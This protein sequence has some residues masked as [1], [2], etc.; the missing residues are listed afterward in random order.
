[1]GLWKRWR[2]GLAALAVSLGALTGGGSA[3]AVPVTQATEIYGTT[4]IYPAPSWIGDDV[5]PKTV[6]GLS[7][8]FRSQQDPVFSLE[9]IP[10]GERYGQWSKLFAVFGQ[11]ADTRS[12]SL[13]Q[14]ASVSL[15][16][17]FAVCGRDGLKIEMLKQTETLTAFLLL[18]PDTPNGAAFPGYG[19]GV[20]EI[21]LF[22]FHKADGVFL[23]VYQEWRGPAYKVA[24]PETWPVTMEELNRMVARF[25][26]IRV[27]ER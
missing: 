12:V 5:D 17:F 9:W 23:K 24:D 13:K 19:K 18:C 2:L 14:F 8:A 21:G 6:I 16:P 3:V 22:H 1:M 15:R 11:Q 10:K 26:T 4:V 25:A 7:E 27:I 20:G